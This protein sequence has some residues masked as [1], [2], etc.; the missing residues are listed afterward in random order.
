[1]ASELSKGNSPMA[2]TTRGELAQEIYLKEW[3]AYTMS[4]GSNRINHLKQVT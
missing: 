1:M 2:K 3:Q 4:P